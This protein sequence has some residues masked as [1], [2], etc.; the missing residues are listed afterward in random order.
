MHWIFVIVTN[1]FGTYLWKWRWRSW[2]KG[3]DQQ[4]QYASMNN[5]DIMAFMDEV[6]LSANRAHLIFNK[7]KY[8]L[9]YLT[10]IF[11]IFF[12]LVTHFIIM[13]APT[14][15]LLHHKTGQQL[16]AVFYIILFQI[17]QTNSRD[18]K[19]TINA[20]ISNWCIAAKP[21]LVFCY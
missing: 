19:W 1:E 3:R 10:C 20:P 17:W 4:E 16:I 18:Q 21:K 9:A 11:K 14:R 6:S 2:E 5:K 7:V 8:F 12:E 15:L 13:I